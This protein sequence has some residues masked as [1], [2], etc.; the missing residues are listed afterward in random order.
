MC[1][2]LERAKERIVTSL[3][4]TIRNNHTCSSKSSLLA[5]PPPKKYNSEFLVVE[6]LFWIDVVG[7]EVEGTNPSTTDIIPAKLHRAI[8]FTTFMMY[9]IDLLYC[10]FILY[11]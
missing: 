9:L 11:I 7:V 4:F 6:I 2:S 8:V 3:T 10:S 5:D 1:E